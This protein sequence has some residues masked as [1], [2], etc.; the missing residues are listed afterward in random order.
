MTTPEVKTALRVLIAD[1]HPPFAEG[2]LRLLNEQPDLET[3]GIATNGEDAVRLALELKPDVVVVDV[4]MP[5]LNGIEATHRIKEL[6]PNTAVLV[7]SA[8]GYSPYVSSA[9]EAGAGGYL[10]KNT[11]LRELMNA[12]RALPAGETV[13]ERSIAEKLLRSMT[14]SQGGVVEG[15]SLSSREL[16]V[17]KLGAHGSSNKEIS[18]Q[19]SLSERTVQAHFTNIFT[20]LGVASRIE[21]IMKAL[22]EGWLTVDDLP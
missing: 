12:I 13:L 11:P 15:A 20:K 5:K 19:L 22:K 17:L 21:A 3:V 6:L 18:E 14:K 8:Y 9:L 16:E 10:L 7:L 2:L 4:A 1:D